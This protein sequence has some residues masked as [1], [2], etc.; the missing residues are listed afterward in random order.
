MHHWCF[1]FG[2]P[3]GNG[4]VR[5]EW[6][7]LIRAMRATKKRRRSHDI[8]ANGFHYPR[9]ETR[10]KREQRNQGGPQPPSEEVVEGLADQVI[11]G[12]SDENWVDLRFA[13]AWNTVPR[14]RAAPAYAKTTIVAIDPAPR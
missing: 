14:E 1:L 3:G 13:L 8:G 12:V 4:S 2:L 7:C 6:R 11:S 5:S 9:G 10:L